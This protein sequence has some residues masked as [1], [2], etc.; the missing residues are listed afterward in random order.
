[1]SVNFYYA[2]SSLKSQHNAL[3][4]GR[5]ILGLGIRRGGVMSAKGSGRE[6]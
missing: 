3:N 6:N 4:A 1:M 5:E 2:W